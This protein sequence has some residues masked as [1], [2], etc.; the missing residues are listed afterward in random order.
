MDATHTLPLS[1]PTRVE[2]TVRGDGQIYG[3]PSGV[4]TV[5]QTQMF[6]EF[7]QKLW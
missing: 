2:P 3:D 6:R 1:S 7:M 4:K 5:H